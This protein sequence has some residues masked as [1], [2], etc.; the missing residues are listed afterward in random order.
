MGWVL[1]RLEWQ[2]RNAADN[3][4][5]DAP[6]E[7]DMLALDIRAFQGA[8]YIKDGAG[9][10]PIATGDLAFQFWQES[11]SSW[12]ESFGEARNMQPGYSVPPTV[13]PPDR[14]EV[15]YRPTLSLVNMAIRTRMRLSWTEFGGDPFTTY[16]SEI[17]VNVQPIPIIRP[18]PPPADLKPLVP[19]HSL[20]VLA[21][22]PTRPALL[23]AK[24]LSCRTGEMTL[25]AVEPDEDIS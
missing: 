12:I 2:H 4:W 18:K 17:V 9:G 10:D 3:A 19:E 6:A 5:V 14:L 8:F 16:S 15:N 23:G 22:A 20:V 24:T 7:F 13:F 1:D 25:H 21:P 11:S